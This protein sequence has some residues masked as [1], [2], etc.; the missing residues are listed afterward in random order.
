MDTGLGKTFLA[1][2]LI[3]KIKEKTLIIIPNKA[4]LEGWYDPF[5]FYLT[6]V[7]LGE[8]HSEKKQ[9]GSVVIMTIDSALS[10]EFIFT[11]GKGKNKKIEKYSSYQYFKKFGLVI[12]DEIHNYPTA[13]QVEIFWRTNFKYGLGLTATPDERADKMDSIYYKHVGSVINAREVPGF[14]DLAEDLKWKGKVSCI[15]FYGSPEY[16]E[17]FKNSLG[18]TDTTEMQKQFAKDPHRT[19]MIV[20]L[21]LEKVKLG[22]NVFVFAVHKNFLNGIHELLIEEDKKQ[23]RET[24]IVEFVGGVSLDDKKKAKDEAQIILT[25]YSFGKEGVSFKKMDTIIF[26]QPMRNRMRQIL[27]RILRRG[28]DQEIVRDITDIRDMNTP[29]ENQFS[30]RKKIYKE[31]SFP[32]EVKKIS[33]DDIF[34]L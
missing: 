7:K 29:L 10:D 5:K 31:K 20:N 12:Y 27:G 1:V 8:Y 30:T 13:T 26:A 6:D 23:N 22:R 17:L 34:M 19:R 24:S 11:Q 21:C 16:T 18:W 28:G 9:D 2:G 15:E 3:E 33:Y 32:I 4:N 14:L 25:T